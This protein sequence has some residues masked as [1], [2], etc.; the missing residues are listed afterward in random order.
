MNQPQ[1]YIDAFK[2]LEEGAVERSVD[3]RISVEGGKRSEFES[4]MRRMR[5]IL[6]TGYQP[7][8][9]DHFAIRRGHRICAAALELWDEPEVSYLE[10]ARQFLSLDSEDPWISATLWHAAIERERLDEFRAAGIKKVEIRGSGCDDDADVC[11]DSDG[12]DFALSAAPELPHKVGEDETPCRCILTA[13]Y[14]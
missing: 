4:A 10:G 6:D 7:S 5:M 9:L 8:A 2:A 14:Q 1:A 11:R 12:K 3:I 13:K